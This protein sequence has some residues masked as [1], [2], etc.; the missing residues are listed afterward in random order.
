MYIKK[1]SGI[2]HTFDV[3]CVLCYQGQ[4]IKYLIILNQLNNH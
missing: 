3:Y 1:Y 2:L 4:M